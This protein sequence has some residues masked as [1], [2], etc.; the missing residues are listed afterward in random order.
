MHHIPY[1]CRLSSA[2]LHVKRVNC[3]GIVVQYTLFPCLL[4]CCS[5]TVLL[6][7][8]ISRKFCYDAGGDLR[9]T[10]IT[11]AS[12][13]FRDAAALSSTVLFFHHWGRCLAPPCIT[14]Y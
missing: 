5:P 8:R 10:L 11:L 6:S 14:L 13:P 1:G 2:S 3:D 12:F 7:P 9:T 4:C